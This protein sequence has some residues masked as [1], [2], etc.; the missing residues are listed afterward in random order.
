MNREEWIEKEVAEQE[1][2]VPLDA[3]NKSTLRSMKGKEFDFWE[4]QAVLVDNHTGH[5]DQ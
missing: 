5:D 3:R 4:R 2:K 1:K